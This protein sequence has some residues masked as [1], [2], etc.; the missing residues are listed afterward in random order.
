MHAEPIGQDLGSKAG[1]GGCSER[2]QWGEVYLT[3][4][5]G[6]LAGVVAEASEEEQRIY[7]AGHQLLGCLIQRQID[8]RELAFTETGEAQKLAGEFF[9]AAALGTEGHGFAGEIANGLDARFVV[10]EEVQ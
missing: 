3:G 7:F 10:A 6:A 2:G 1:I 9:R 5:Q 8:E 4:L